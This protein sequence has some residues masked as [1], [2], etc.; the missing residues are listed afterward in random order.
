MM[1]VAFFGDAEHSFRLTAPMVIELERKTGAGI[2]ALCTRVFAKQFSQ[3]DLQETIRCALIGGGMDPKRAAEMIAAYA[4]DR[5]IME[6][7]SLA[8]AV[9][10]AAFFGL[11]NQKE[12][13]GQA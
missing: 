7:Y 4:V 11:P 5:P 8:V 12:V 3:S 10:E 2:G 1:H 6:I 13:N 9:V